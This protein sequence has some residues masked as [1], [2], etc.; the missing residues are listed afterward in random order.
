MT[1]ANRQAVQQCLTGWKEEGDKQGNKWERTR[2][3]SKQTVDAASGQQGESRQHFGR[4][5][6]EEGM[7]QI[8]AWEGTLRAVREWGVKQMQGTAN[9][10][11]NGDSKHGPTWKLTRSASQVLKWWDEARKRQS[12]EMVIYTKKKLRVQSRNL[13][14][15]SC[16]K[17]VYK[18]RNQAVARIIQQDWQWEPV[19]KENGEGKQEK[20]GLVLC[21]VGHGKQYMLVAWKWISEEKWEVQGW[22]SGRRKWCL[23]F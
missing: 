5:V 16:R 10:L 6:E 2:K 4:Q 8:K 17:D 11:L 1:R 9:A 3:K 13:T 22:Q 14:F 7:Q 18:L 20:K 15:K 12:R 23:E 21:K 19:A